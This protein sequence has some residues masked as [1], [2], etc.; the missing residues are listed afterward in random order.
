M[1]IS[2]EA[3]QLVGTIGGLEVL[4]IGKGDLRDKD[5]AFLPRL[6]VLKELWIDGSDTVGD[7]DQPHGLTDRAAAMISKLPD[8]E[9]LRINGEGPYSDEFAKAILQLPKLRH[10]DI[11]S[12]SLTD[13]TLARL[14]EK[15]SIEE[16][17]ISSSRFTP[18]AMRALFESRT[19]QKLEVRSAKLKFQLKR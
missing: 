3:L 7:P 2:S 12:D 19:I 11:T 16:V 9:R 8:L 15:E 4:W 18:K 6:K 17:I 10:L 14:V 13:E 5:L 1:E